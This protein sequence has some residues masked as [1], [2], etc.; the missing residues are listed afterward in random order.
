MSVIINPNTL[1]AV[2]LAAAG[3]HEPRARLQG[4]N[5]VAEA[6]STTYVA[7]SGAVLI[8]AR[9]HVTN[10]T[11]GSW[12]IPAAFCAAR[13]KVK[14]LGDDQYTLTVEAGKL[15]YSVG[16]YGEHVETIDDEYPDWRRCIP[17]DVTGKAGQFFP[18]QF[19][20]FR[21]AGKIA[22]WGAPYWHHNGDDMPAAITF[23]ANSNVIGMAMPA[24]LGNDRLHVPSWA[25]R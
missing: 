20:V 12:I 9:E 15:F 21:Q 10:T 6:D 24:R 19:K 23:T 8:A 18:E 16:A 2:S 14:G 17:Y 22:D 13:K 5:V 11:T 3:K 25:R 4:V 1:R 7:T